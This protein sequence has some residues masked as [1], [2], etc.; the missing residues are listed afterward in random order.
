MI[1]MTELSVSKW[2]LDRVSP[3]SFESLAGFAA[4]ASLY[5][6]SFDALRLFF[7]LLVMI[8]VG[9]LW[10]RNAKLSL[11]YSYKGGLYATVLF[12]LA[13]YFSG[14]FLS[15]ALSLERSLSV[16]DIGIFLLQGVM[17]AMLLLTAGYGRFALAVGVWAVVFALI[18]A[19]ANL[20][21]VVGWIDIRE[22]VRLIDGAVQYAYPGLSGNTLAGGFVCFVAICR[23]ALAAE[24]VGSIRWI[25]YALIL[26]LLVSLE[27]ISAR[28]YLGLAL[29][30]VT[31]FF[32]W[33]WISRIG[34][35]WVSLG[36][37]SLFLILTFT[38]SEGDSGNW[39]RSS[40]MLNGISLA[41]ENLIIGRGP[42]YVALD[43]LTANYIELSNAYVT[44]SQ[45]LDFAINYGTL[46]AF[47]LFLALLIT[48]A[49]QSNSLHKYPAIIL[50]CMTAELF[51][52]GS[53][54]SF[55][56]VLLFYST[57]GA[58]LESLKRSRHSSASL[59]KRCRKN[60]VS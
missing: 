39:L 1:I 4:I 55:A 9:M 11:K 3:T 38:A 23:L 36:L 37:A 5:A 30:A 33:R 14:V 19:A 16:N 56:G 31:L 44:E 15:F 29:A 26:L 18:D 49:A 21:G 45:L 25:Y 28:R 20:L 10:L 8:I 22:P 47:A 24:Q 58:C 7:Q 46:S 54:S 6:G 60:E 17:A 41:L 50:T 59:N 52:G 48:L 2:T 34:L 35:Q 57:L 40:L 27:L 53:L 32:I 42:T 13:V 43:G 51:F 12:L